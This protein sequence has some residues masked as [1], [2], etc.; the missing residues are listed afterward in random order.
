MTF[1]SARLDRIKPS[2]SSMAGQRVREL[3]T[4]GRDIIG[5]TL[6]EPDFETPENIIESA[7]RAMA[8]SET[9]YTDVG[10]TPKLKEAIQHKFLRDNKLDYELNEI[11]A[12]TGAKQIIFNAFMSTVDAGDEVI[13]PAPYWVSYPDIVLLA[14]GKP[15]LVPCP[16][17]AGFKLLPQHL[18]RAITP[19]TKWVV[20]NSPNNPSG[21]VYTRDE[22]CQLGE[23]LLRHPHV[24][25]LC[26]DIYEHILYDHRSFS[27]LAEVQPNLRARTLTVNGVSKAYAMTGWRLGFGA[28]PV[29][30]IKT[31]V[32]LQSQSTSNPNSISQAAAIEALV[33]PQQI[34]RKRTKIFQERR[35]ML[36]E[37]L[38]AIPGLSCEPPEG[39]FYAYPSCTELLGRKTPQGTVIESD[40][41]FAMYLLDTTNVAV[42][43]GSV[44]GLSPHLRISFATSMDTLERGCLRLS[45]AC[46][47]LF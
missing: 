25:I 34:V 45:A 28:G 32:K 7:V 4:Q 22:L 17:S 21:A 42:L 33:G 13:V 36:V 43:P 37:R 1:I 18:E 8:S 46:E 31:M 15:V 5:L 35:D 23:V 10:G 41:D 29:E 27:T 24:W 14:G 6:G 12:G 30:L 9:R 47:A 19:R 16:A 38:N 2:P 44:Y 3:R 11:V 40:T 26:D 20:L 39:A